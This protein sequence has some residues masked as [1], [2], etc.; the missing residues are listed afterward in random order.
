MSLRCLAAAAALCL[1]AACGADGD[2]ERPDGAPVGPTVGVSVSGT[3]EIG[4]SG[5]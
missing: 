5:S 4:V 3:V 1:L 2:P